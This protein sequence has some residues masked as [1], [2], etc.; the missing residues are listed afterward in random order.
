M[1]VPGSAVPNTMTSL[2]GEVHKTHGAG[3]CCLWLAER[4][5][6]CPFD[7][8][9]CQNRS[10]I[11]HHK[12]NSLPAMLLKTTPG[13]FTTA[14]SRTCILLRT[15]S[16]P[17]LAAAAVISGFIACS[18]MSP[19]ALQRRGPRNHLPASFPVCPSCAAQ[20]YCVNG[21]PALRPASASIW[22]RAPTNR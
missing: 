19:I 16:P 7:R 14:F 3:S 8:E 2:F 4:I 11:K 21:V 20:P 9:L 10:C 13:L 17:C 5:R 18:S 15:H 6:A 22:W 1:K 12:R